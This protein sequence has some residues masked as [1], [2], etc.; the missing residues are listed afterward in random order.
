MENL[1]YVLAAFGVTWV[2]LWL[3]VYS[4]WQKQDRIEQGLQRL[5]E[6]LNAK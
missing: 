5:Q 1:S 2:G 3:Y 4:L 6:Q